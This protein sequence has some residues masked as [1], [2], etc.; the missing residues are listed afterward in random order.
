M[1]LLPPTPPPRPALLPLPTFARFFN[2]ALT[3][4]SSQPRYPAASNMPGRQVLQSTFDAIVREA[5]SDFGLSA[6]AAVADAREQLSAAGVTDFSNL[7]DPTACG[8]GTDAGA[9]ERARAGRFVAELGDLLVSEDAAGE[10][11]DEYGDGDGEEDDDDDDAQLARLLRDAFAP[12][13]RKG[14]ATGHEFCAVVGATGGAAFVARALARGVARVRRGRWELA[15]AACDAVRGLV[16]GNEA[17]RGRLVLGHVGDKG[18]GDADADADIG[19]DIDVVDCLKTIVVLGDAGTEA[20]RDAALRGLRAIG[21]V[22][23]QCEAVKQRVASEGF[24]ET[25]LGAVSRGAGG[26]DWRTFFAGAGVLRGSLAADDGS[27]EA[28]E[29]F[30]RARVLGGGGAATGSGLR[31]LEGGEDSALPAVVCCVA[32]QAEETG[33]GRDDVVGEC[34]AVGRACAIADEVCRGLY[35]AGLHVVAERL[36]SRGGGGAGTARGCVLLLRNVGGLDEA[37]TA[38][39]EAL[40]RVTA[41]LGRVGTLERSAAAC[42]ALCGAVA[43]VCLRR[44]D[45]A[46]G[47]ARAGVAATVVRA[48][49]RHGAAVARAGC[50]AVRNLCAR[51]AAARQAVVAAGGEAAVRQVW[52]ESG[53]HE[54]GYAALREMRR[55]R[56]HEER[57]DE[58]YTMPAGFFESKGAARA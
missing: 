8:D 16:R 10:D 11:E 37:K 9:R 45:V 41:A 42:E 18:A 31:V 27:V 23:R 25:V 6:S 17:N 4:P 5:M 56:S 43:A 2:S 35:R 7:R 53:V 32:R 20:G 14:E 51:S 49:Q 44:A 57:R 3:P 38:I 22:Q 26:D 54:A 40:V 29:T 21:P 47:C 39:Y 48:M 24:L 36:V 15:A 19:T 52:K 58:R 28:G 34:V 1:V 33:A 12:D 46:D 30:N 55:L 13:D 50:L